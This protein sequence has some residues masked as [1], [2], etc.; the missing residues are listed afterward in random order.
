MFFQTYRLGLRLIA[1]TCVCV[2]IGAMGGILLAVSQEFRWRHQRQTWEID[3]VQQEL[4]GQVK[5]PA[6]NNLRDQLWTATS[7]QLQQLRERYACVAALG[8]VD[9]ISGSVLAGA[10]DARRIP[11]ENISRWVSQGETNRPVETGAGC[12]TWAFPWPSPDG[13]TAFWG[14]VCYQHPGWLE[15]AQRF[16]AKLI[17]WVTPVLLL[18][19]L[20][21]WWLIGRPLFNLR[22][23]WLAQLPEGDAAPPAERL[24]LE[25]TPLEW[26]PLA[27]RINCLLDQVVRAKQTSRE[28]EQ[29]LSQAQKQFHLNRQDQLRILD[30]RD[31]QH[32]VMRQQVDW[33]TAQAGDGFVLVEP[34][35]RV[36]SANGKACIWLQLEGA[37][38]SFLTHPELIRA[39]NLVIAENSGAQ[40]RGTL[41]ISNR[42]N[43]GVRLFEFQALGVGRPNQPA[44]QAV[45][46]LREVAMTTNAPA[47]E[48][49][50]LVWDR[51][52]AQ[53]DQARFAPEDA[54]ASKDL[55]E[56]AVINRLMKAAHAPGQLAKVAVLFPNGL[57]TLLRNAS[58]LLDRPWMIDVMEKPEGD[59]PAQAGFEVWQAWL[60]G[61]GWFLATR[62]G[63]TK[64]TAS[65]DCAG[66]EGQLLLNLD[67]SAEEA[68]R[69]LARLLQSDPAEADDC[70][71]ALLMLEAK[72]C[73]IQ[74][75][76]SEEDPRRLVLRFPVRNTPEVPLT[77]PVMAVTNAVDRATGNA[78]WRQ[79]VKS[80]LRK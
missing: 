42:F 26:R 34:S 2:A 29:L 13:T 61:L 55:R 59:L 16:T 41:Q 4:F 53:L 43:T 31:Y 49:W 66:E 1:V 33:L 21:G 60:E 15:L 63:A 48:A 39:V 11:V 50:S 68:P 7:A 72:R 74:L 67:E 6:T 80:F 65:A 58:R 19:L 14:V 22:K 70:L 25:A 64:L 77:S 8:V 30:Q 75:E 56:I 46:L 57:L 23:Q 79:F 5:L 38:K 78:D 24:P 35:G 28:S 76:I 40:T 47:Q 62:C 17:T 71:G 45:L 54:P 69:F 44:D 73:Q 12:E 20:A 32:Q 36:I 10:G 3:K 9:R 27:T 37:L 18:G 51:W 52:L